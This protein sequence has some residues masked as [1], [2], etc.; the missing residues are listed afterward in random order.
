MLIAVVAAFGN[1]LRGWDSATIAGKYSYSKGQAF[2]L[3]KREKNIRPV[4]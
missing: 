1:L 3:F 4:F 2:K